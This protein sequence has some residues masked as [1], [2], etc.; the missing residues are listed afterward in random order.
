MECHVIGCNSK[1]MCCRKC[2]YR[3]L[4]LLRIY[5]KT[6]SAEEFMHDPWLFSLLW[7]MPAMNSIEMVAVKA[8]YNGWVSTLTVRCIFVYY[9]DAEIHSVSFHLLWSLIDV[10]HYFSTIMVLSMETRITLEKFCDDMR[11][12]FKFGEDDEF[13]MKWLDEEG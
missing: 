7:S 9:T 5:R 4:T 13:T 3:K 12:I 6:V 8:A 2:R 1:E 11:D 10:L